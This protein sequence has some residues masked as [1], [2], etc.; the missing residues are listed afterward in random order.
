MP[1]LRPLL[2]C[3]LSVLPSWSATFGTVVA[4]PQSLADLVLDEARKR[5]Y[6]V[7]TYSNQVDV[8]STASNPPSLVT[9]INTDATPLAVAMSRSGKSLYVACYTA[10]TLDIFDLT[11]AAFSKTS[12]SLGANPEGVAV[13][14]NE[15]VLIST[16]G[17]GTGQAVLTTYTPSASGS[18]SAL[19]AIVVAPTPPTT[20]QLPPP[21]GLMYFAS[22][23]QL[24]ATPDGT[25][26]VGVNQQATTRT[27]FVFDVASSTVLASRT[28]AATSPILAV[29]PDGSEFLS[30]PMLFETSTLLVLAQQNTTN[31]PFVFASGANF[32]TQTNQGGAVFLPDGSE[33][34]TAYNIVPVQNPAAKPNTSQLLVNTPDSLLIQMGVMLPENL[35]GKIVISSDGATMYAIS[36]SGFLV[37]STAGLKT[38]PV[39]IPDTN[40]TLLVNDQCGVTASQNSAVIPVRNQGGGKLTVTAQV[41]PSAATSA[42]VRVSAKS[43]GP[44]WCRAPSILTFLEPRPR[45]PRPKPWPP[46]RMAPSF[47]CWGALAGAIFIA[48]LSTTSWPRGR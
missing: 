9:T 5:I 43:Y 17:T 4:H 42:Q 15:L 24:Q 6:L 8:Y 26:I 14:Y 28:I 40:V 46:A 41:L 11:S 21:N 10:S 12:V 29:S 30:G 47:C 33:L 16:I 13:G 3:V 19:Q 34:L 22:K 23:S 38:S 32:T 37:A 44:L 27:V 7:D 2:V 25:R 36:Q 31:S 1:V 35:G 20:P 45:S 18:S 39:A 48:P